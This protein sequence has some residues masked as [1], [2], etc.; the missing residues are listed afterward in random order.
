MASEELKSKYQKR[1]KCELYNDNYENWKR[2]PIH[3]A[4]LI[5]T[6]VPYNIGANAF[7]SNPM[8]Y[9]GGDNAN[10]ESKYAKASFFR[11]DGYFKPAEYM[12]FVSQLLK[13]EPTGKVERGKSSNAPCMLLFCAYEQMNYFIELAQRYGLPH[14][15]PLFFIKNYSAQVLKAN[16]RVVGATEFALLFWRDRLPKFRNDGQMVFDWFPWE[17]DGKDIPKIHNT[18]KPIKLLKRLIS[19][20]TDPGDVV[21]DPCA[22]SA[23]TLRAAY[24][25]GRNSY[26]FEIDRDMYKQAT[27][28]MLANIKPDENA[29]RFLQESLFA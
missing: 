5:L 14:Y 19:I 22:G 25:L 26:G 6:D 28:K 12:H 18:Q 2:Y 20:F 10:G 3:K 11:S 27:A 17:R 9:E 1:I 13:K 8:W 4:Q 24:E 29:D 23:S 16:M 7:G 21:I 15:K